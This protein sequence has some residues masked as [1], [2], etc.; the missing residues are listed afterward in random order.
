MEFPF[1]GGS[2]FD[3]HGQGY[4]KIVL[5]SLS[6]YMC[7]PPICIGLTR[8]IWLAMMLCFHASRSGLL[9]LVVSLLVEL[10]SLFLLDEC[11]F[12]FCSIQNS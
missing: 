2:R 7:H 8:R 11:I 5:G 10:K 9:Q 4:V 3:W 1:S 6:F 12:T